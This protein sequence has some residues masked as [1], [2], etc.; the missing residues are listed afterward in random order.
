MDLPLRRRS[1]VKKQKYLIIAMDKMRTM[2]KQVTGTKTQ[3][4]MLILHLICL[5]NKKD[6][7][8]VR[9][10]LQKILSMIQ[11]WLDHTQE[12]HMLFL[13]KGHDFHPECKLGICDLV[14]LIQEHRV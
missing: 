3:Q 14:F 12:V 7:T 1:Q 13:L 9:N 8:T 5:M 10:L 2:V 6:L 11:T 4:K